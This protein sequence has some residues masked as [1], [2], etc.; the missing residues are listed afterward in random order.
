MDKKIEVCHEFIGR[1]PSY[2]NSKDR[3]FLSFMVDKEKFSVRF[4][5]DKRKVKDSEEHLQNFF[6][7]F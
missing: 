3:G 6:E 1:L 7:K 4:F 5:Y 2:F